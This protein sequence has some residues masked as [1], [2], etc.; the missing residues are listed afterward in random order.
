MKSLYESILDDIDVSIENGQDI[1]EEH[2]ILKL[3][4]NPDWFTMSQYNDIE[5]YQL[6]INLENSIEVFSLP[7]ISNVII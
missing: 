7:S 2:H 3:L 1:A 6:S 4:K 5:K